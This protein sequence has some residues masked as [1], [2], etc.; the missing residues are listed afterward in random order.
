MNPVM[1]IIFPT[2]DALPMTHGKSLAQAGHA[3]VEAYRLSCKTDGGNFQESSIANRWRRGGHYTKI[4]LMD[5]DLPTA[6]EYIRA[7]G[8]EATLIIDEGRTEF[9]G[10][11][12]PTAIGVEIVDKDSKHVQETF[13]AFKTYR[14]SNPE[15]VI[16]EATGIVTAS[17]RE[18]IKGF[19]RNGDIEGARDALRQSARRKRWWRR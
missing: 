14:V 18:N 4:A 6:L 5:F 13:G 16:L 12:T 9:D 15:P 3:A 8:F 7:R 17:Q 11:L 1:Y 2:P 10:R 19:I